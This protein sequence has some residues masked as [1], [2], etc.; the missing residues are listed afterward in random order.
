MIILKMNIWGN[1]ALNLI[2]R[3]SSYLAEFIYSN[4]DNK[5][6]H[7][8]HRGHLFRWSFSGWLTCRK[9]FKIFFSILGVIFRL[10]CLG[11]AS[12]IWIS[13][14]AARQQDWNE[15]SG[16]RLLSEVNG[17]DIFANLQLRGSESD[18]KIHKWK[19][20]Q[21]NKNDVFKDSR[22]NDGKRT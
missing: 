13:F 3:F 9:R 21:I 22:W 4:T 11:I 6:H 8:G 17:R 10:L 19:G 18:M 15:T 14:I 1:L 2:F 20:K 5:V 7:S 12:G 16:F